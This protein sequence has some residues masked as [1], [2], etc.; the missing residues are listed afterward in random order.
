[1][2]MLVR[3][4][5]LMS[6]LLG[7]LGASA[8]DVLS[9]AS[10][11]ANAGTTASVAVYLQDVAGT[12]L[13]Y[14]AP[15]GNRIQGI[16]FRVTYDPSKVS[17]VTFTRAGALQNITPLYERTSTATGSIGYLGAFAEATQPVPLSI[18]ALTGA[19]IGTLSV[20]LA[21]SLANGTVIPLTLDPAVSTLSNQVATAFEN[22]YNRKLT[23]SSGSI[24]IGGTSTTTTLGSN[25][26]PSTT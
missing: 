7:A 26:N 4:A 5:A 16:A 22:R 20:Q 11:S 21:P 3:S 8:Q 15:V 19:R 25:P 9:V 18:T 13:G 2:K 10:T 12:P 17:S 23:L 1:M 24:V 6:L 14:D